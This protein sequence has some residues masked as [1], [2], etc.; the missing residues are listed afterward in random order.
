MA[1]V[2]EKQLEEEVPDFEEHAAEIHGDFDISATVSAV[3]VHGWKQ[4]LGI[5][6][7]AILIL[8]PY[9]IAQSCFKEN[10]DP[11]YFLMV[12]TAFSIFT[13][14]FFPY[15]LYISYLYMEYSI[16]CILEW[17][18]YF[19]PHGI[20]ETIIILSAGSTGMIMNKNISKKGIK[21]KLSIEEALK[22]LIIVTSLLSVTASIEIF[23]SPLFLY[24][25]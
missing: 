5:L 1:D 25:F 17:I 9:L 23:I 20:L 12:F 16:S 6:G 18:L 14:G 13:Y 11:E 7:V 19:I 3:R 2:Y 4:V 21:Q 8:G 24:F 10:K 22:K 15:G